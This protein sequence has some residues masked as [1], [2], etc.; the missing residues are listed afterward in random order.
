MILQARDQHFTSI[1]LYSVPTRC[2]RRAIKCL[3]SHQSITAVSVAKKPEG[4]AGGTTAHYMNGSA[5]GD[6]A[7][8]SSERTKLAPLRNAGVNMTVTAIHA[9]HLRNP[10]GLKVLMP[11]GV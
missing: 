11:L 2:N 9:I 3:D 1:L 8:S 6:I 5:E 4:T 10:P 7:H